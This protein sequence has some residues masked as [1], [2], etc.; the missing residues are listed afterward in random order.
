MKS[1]FK[2]FKKTKQEDKPEKVGLF[3]GLFLNGLERALK[4]D[5]T[6]QKTLRDADKNLEKISDSLHDFEDRGYDIP[7][8]LK[9]YKKNK[10]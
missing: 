5:K 8:E 9:K 6:L 4:N 10:K 3:G 7:E 2:L 1:L